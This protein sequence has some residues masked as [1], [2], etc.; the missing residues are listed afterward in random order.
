MRGIIVYPVGCLYRL[1]FRQL[2]H[3]L[4]HS[5]INVIPVTFLFMLLNIDVDYVVKLFF[6]LNLVNS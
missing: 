6:G 4:S 3:S 5:T 1:F 2:S